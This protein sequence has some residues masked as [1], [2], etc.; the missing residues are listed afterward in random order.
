[1][2]VLC[3]EVCYRFVLRETGEIFQDSDFKQLYR[4]VRHHIRG[5]VGCSEKYRY[6]NGIFEYGV[7]MRYSDNTW[8][9]K[10]LRNVCYMDIDGCST[11]P[12]SEYV[13]TY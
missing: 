8:C 1:M 4:F 10:C 5:E 11:L 13:A 2:K 9:F 12:L 6:L 7:Y 3:A